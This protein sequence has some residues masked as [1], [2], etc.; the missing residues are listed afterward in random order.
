MTQG[1]GARWGAVLTLRG[2]P[3]TSALTAARRRSDGALA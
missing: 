3:K 1:Y 2:A